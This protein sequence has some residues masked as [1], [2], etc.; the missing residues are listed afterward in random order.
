MEGRNAGASEEIVK[1]EQG[2]IDRRSS[3][4][5]LSRAIG[6]IDLALEELEQ[7]NLADRGRIPQNVARQI[8]LLMRSVPLDL[9]PSPEQRSVEGLMDDLYR[10]ER[11][12]LIRRSGPGWDDLGDSEDELLPSA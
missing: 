6:A 3:N 4:L 11:S 9:R 2:E 1:L 12:L 8:V 7:L 5:R 10:A